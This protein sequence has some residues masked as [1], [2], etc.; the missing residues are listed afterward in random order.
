MVVV[1]PASKVKVDDDNL[2]K[3]L[4]VVLPVMVWSPVEKVTVP[5]LGVKVSE[6][7]QLPVKVIP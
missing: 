4:K 3:L 2:E 7:V 5:D 1:E 6:L